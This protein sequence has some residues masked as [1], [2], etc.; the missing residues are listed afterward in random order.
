MEGEIY[1]ENCK[2]KFDENDRIPMTLPCSHPICSNCL[3]SFKPGDKLTCP[4]CGLDLSK[5]NLKE[6]K[7]HQM[8]LSLIRNQL[9]SQL[10]SVNSEEQSESGQYEEQSENN[11]EANA[12]EMNNTSQYNNCNIQNINNPIE[13]CVKHKEKEIEFFCQ[14]CTTVV[15]SL[16]IFETHNGHHLTLL[17]DMSTII[18]NNVKDFGKILKNLEKV[19]ED[20]QTNA[21]S[22]LDDVDKQKQTQITM[23]TKS[24]DEILKKIEEKKTSI[25]EEFNN[26]YFH[27]IKRFKKIQ[28]CLQSNQG[29]IERI[30][31]INEELTKNFEK[32]SDAKILKKIDE[33]TSFLH[34]SA[35]DIKRLY[36]TEISL[37]AELIIDPAMKPIPINISELIHLLEKIDPKTICYPIDDSSLEETDTSNNNGISKQY[38]RP[39][40]LE[41]P[42][43]DNEINNYINRIGPGDSSNQ[44]SEDEIPN[45]IGEY[46]LNRSKGGKFYKIPKQK[47]SKYYLKTREKHLNSHHSHQA[48]LN[49]SN[50][51]FDS[52][53]TPGGIGGKVNYRNNSAH[54]RYMSTQGNNDFTNNSITQMQQYVQRASN[55]INN[56]FPSDMNQINSNGQFKMKHRIPSAGNAGERNSTVSLPKIAKSNSFSSQEDPGEPAI[57]C[58]GEADYCLKYYINKG[59]WDIVKFT[60]EDSR[61]LGSVRYS[62]V[63]SIP[64]QKLILTG[65]CKTSNDEPTNIVIEASANNV[66]K[67]KILK[68]MIMK[69]YG[70]S[71]VFIN[72]VLFVVG[73][74]EHI[75]RTQTSMLS[76][77]KTCEKFD[78]GKNRWEIIAPLNHPRA[79]FGNVIYKN[80]LFVFG[81]VYN[82]QLLSSI[83]K[84]DTYT[85]VWIT[86]HIKLPEKLAK[87]GII[88]YNKDIIIILGGVNED[89]EIV[90]SVKQGR[91]DTKSSNNWFKAPDMICPRGV[92]NSAF[93]FGDNIIVLGGSV[94]GV[95][96]RFDF[97][98]KK[99]EMIESYYKVIKEKK[100]E[101]IIKNFSCV[102]NY[103]V[104]P[105]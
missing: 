13:Y 4:K 64:G 81:G 48:G 94:E 99:W 35:M 6:L 101:K 84:Y 82:N 23:V 39:I 11:S 85:N 93:L 96:E 28:T 8:I 78:I 105:S 47:N 79:F 33:F 14:T 77:L 56:I 38:V 95:C 30:A 73:G 18:K 66:N 15:C 43:F 1:C 34:K 12:N 17:E 42:S 2:G 54:H 104:S 22:K 19:N 55:H 27:E 69:R 98:T 61:L 44:N 25:I 97:A 87:M 100:I 41:R 68:Q 102:L 71:S 75:D 3:S 103:Y 9:N 52:T 70:H 32:F 76:T 60:N 50:N 10:N 45:K 89:Y 5:V 62:S 26:K 63:T 58:F 16:C 57:Y 65:G 90:S 80:S 59:E 72:N 88:N 51:N 31:H 83:E 91:L 37:K 86:Y 24:F 92:S 21:E 49:K 36:K 40:N 7:P 74:Y 29:Q 53:L 20:N 46:S 67:V